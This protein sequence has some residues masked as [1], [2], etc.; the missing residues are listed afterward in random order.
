MNVWR[1]DD[2]AGS[3]PCRGV[4]TSEPRRG[5]AY[6]TVPYPTPSTKSFSIAC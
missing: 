5:L 1:A 6:L 4:G 3:T 2:G